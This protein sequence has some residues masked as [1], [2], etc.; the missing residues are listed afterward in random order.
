MRYRVDVANTLQVP[1][2]MN[3]IRF[4]GDDLRDARW[5]FERWLPGFD[6]W[7]RPNASY[8]VVLSEYDGRLGDYR[9][10]DHKGIGLA[11]LRVR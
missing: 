9:I 5:V 4:L 7:Y 10:I 1:C 11:V 3:S 8:G 6:S 2:G